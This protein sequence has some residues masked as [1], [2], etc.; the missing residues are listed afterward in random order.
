[1]DV[2]I[3]AALIALSG[4]FITALFGLISY[5]YKV[6]LE[7]KKS[8][9]SLLY[10]LME[11]RYSII[12][13]LFDPDEACDSYIKHITVKLNELGVSASTEQTDLDLRTTLLEYFYNL[14]NTI[15]VDIKDRLL[16]PFEEALTELATIDPILAYQIKGKENLQQLLANNDDHFKKV[17]QTIMPNLNQDW[18][19]QSILESTHKVKQDV[20]DYICSNLEKEILMVAK[21]CSKKD[22]KKC[23]RA[24]N[25]G[26]TNENKYSY[27]D[28]DEMI[29]PIFKK[30]ISDA[31]TA[32]SS[33]VQ[34]AEE[35]AP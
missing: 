35:M 10:I 25:K 33:H 27:S 32:K 29:L 15:S 1:M 2:K 34:K 8:A 13:S 7:K 19:K 26:L 11:L 5:R 17:H 6:E 24:M 4:I 18:A 23:K 28:L 20:I 14:R 31:N 12:T 3:T 9:R 22:L 16:E 21:N 30:I